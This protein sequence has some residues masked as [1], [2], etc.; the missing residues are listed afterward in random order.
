[1][2]TQGRTAIPRCWSVPSW[3]WALFIWWL[4]P[5]APARA[6]DDPRPVLLERGRELL[7]RRW[8]PDDPRS[9]GGDGL[10]PVYN[11]TSCV[12]CHSLGGP[13]GGGVADESVEIL[14]LARPP[15]PLFF[16]KE[17]NEE[18]AR[19]H[20][21]LRR[22][23][24]VI[25][26]RF[27]TQPEYGPWRGKLLEA[28]HL[29]PRPKPPTKFPLIA[30]RMERRL[31]ERELS[32]GGTHQ[33]GRRFV[34]VRRNAPALFGAGMIDA[35]PDAVLELADEQE[36]ADFPETRGRL[37]RLGD[38]MI[39][40]L[41]RKAQTATLRESVMTAC[42]VEIGLEVPGHHQARS[43][44][45]PDADAKGLDL[46]QEE[47]DALTAYVSHLPAPIDR[48]SPARPRSASALAGRRL[49]ESIGCAAC[50]RPR[51]GDIEGIYSDLLLHDMGPESADV[52]RAEY[53]TTDRDSSGMALASEWRTPPVW[54]VRDSG[55]YL[56]DGRAKTLEMA[57]TLHG[58]QGL[59]SANRFVRLAPKERLQV[60]AFLR[61]LAPPASSDRSGSS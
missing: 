40:P 13:G 19:V 37:N 15:N 50:H 31:R 28:E 18:L 60:E 9:H 6:V 36:Y 46:T 16:G 53:G 29:V 10:G 4:I 52:G 44:L 21:G 26:L 12:A 61:S 45:V 20:P 47:C 35:L 58:G 25:L 30:E 7:V 3:R 57:V 2:S 24:A 39:G 51:L 1:L 54:G 48:T 32:E 43:P 33:P 23:I 38:G 17:I 41:G 34:L 59:A 27:G 14:S 22:S 56:H 5:I 42:A 11:G 49:F 8:L 55:P